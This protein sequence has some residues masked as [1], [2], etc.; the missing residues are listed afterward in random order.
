MPRGKKTCTK[1][2][3]ETGPR[4]FVCKNCNQPFAFKLKT[5]EQRTTRLIKDVNWKELTKGDIIKV[6]GGPYFFY[7]GEPVSM[8]YRGKFVVEKIDDKGICAWG[9][10]KNTGFA[11]IYM[12]RDVQNPDTGV[13]KVKHRI[14]KVKKK[15]TNNRNKVLSGV[16]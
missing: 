4:S 13:W 7:N 10:G 3:T 16:N 1:C 9:I 5:R 14:A 2:G 8:G 6:T 12:G 15:E 11:H